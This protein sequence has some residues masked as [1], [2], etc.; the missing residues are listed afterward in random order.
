[1]SLEPIAEERHRFADQA[2]LDLVR[3]VVAGDWDPVRAATTLRRCITEEATLEQ[4]RTVVA[5]TPL[6]DTWTDV[7]HARAAYT[8]DIAR[9]ATERL[10]CDISGHPSRRRHHR[11]VRKSA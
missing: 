7:V 10:P 1:M 5:H 4:M 2:L 11:E 8:I 9:D 6:D 3:L